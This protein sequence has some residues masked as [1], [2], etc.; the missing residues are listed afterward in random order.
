MKPCAPPGF[1]FSP[2]IPLP[3]SCRSIKLCIVTAVF[4]QPQT[5]PYLSTTFT[6]AVAL[7]VRSRARDS[8]K[9]LARSLA[10][11]SSACFPSSCLKSDALL[12]PVY[13]FASRQLI[14]GES[15]F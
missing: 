13:A 3:L 10:L 1:V 6:H 5:L 11:H 4:G 12:L 2:S 8:N 9:I 14:P 15:S 7:A